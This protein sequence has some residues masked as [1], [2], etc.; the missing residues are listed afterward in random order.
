M[1]HRSSPPLRIAWLLALA[2]GPSACRPRS[3][4]PVSIVAVRAASLVDFGRTWV[5][6]PQRRDLEIVNPNQVSVAL[7]F[8]TTEPFAVIAAPSEV[9][10]GA[11]AVATLE[12]H[13]MDAGVFGATLVLDELELSLLGEGAVPFACG[14]ATACANVAFDP[15][16]GT[17]LTTPRVDGTDCTASSACFAAAR[18]EGG[19][20]VGSLTTCDDHDACTL[21]V[22]GQGGCTHLDAPR[23][24]AAVPRAPGALPGRDL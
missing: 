19:T 15:D 20:C 9:A 7:Q 2:L 6:F 8:S 24:A 21:D 11:S 17:C 18:C 10:P 23:R 4:A 14:D 22:C 13:P 5:G 3:A 1:G 12:F 16:A